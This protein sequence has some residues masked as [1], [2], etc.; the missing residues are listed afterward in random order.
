MA[1]LKNIPTE[2][3]VVAA[4]VTNERGELLLQKR[5]PNGR[6]AGLWEF[7]GGKVEIGE[8]PENALVRELEEEL[9]VRID[10]RY[11]EK[12]GSASEAAAG[13]YPAIVMILYKTGILPGEPVARQQQEWGWFDRDRAR[14]LPMPAVDLE[15]LAE[16][17]GHAS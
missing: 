17:A 2:I 9:G 14:Q 6:H 13:G 16:L 1:E 15:L 11:L 4:A 7:P 3:L 5:G 10:S 8:T 12:F